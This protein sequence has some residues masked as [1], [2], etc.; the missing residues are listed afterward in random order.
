MVENADSEITALSHF[1]PDSELIIDKR[2]KKQVKD[3]TYKKDSSANIKLI[4]Y[5]P[6]YLEYTSN[7]KVDQ[8][9]VFS[10]IYYDKGWDAFID[11]K[12]S[13]YFRANY[14]LRAMK[15]P[16]GKH[17][18]KFQFKPKSYIIGNNISIVSSSILILLLIGIFANEFLRKKEKNI[19]HKNI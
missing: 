15:I 14:V 5:K 2:F 8:L 18:I 1:K 19:I 4:N 13:P 17:T 10:E 11:G 3:F 9:A 7:S 12:L 6:N 16:A